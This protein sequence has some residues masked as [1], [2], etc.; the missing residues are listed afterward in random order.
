MKELLHIADGF[1][2]LLKELPVSSFA[3]FLEESGRKIR[4]IADNTVFHIDLFCCTNASAA[5]KKIMQS[6]QENETPYKLLIKNE[7]NYTV[8]IFEDPIPAVA[9][10]IWDEAMQ[11]CDALIRY[12]KKENND[13][14]AMFLV[15][16]LGNTHNIQSLI[17]QSEQSVKTFFLPPEKVNSGHLSTILTADIHPSS[18]EQLQQLSC[19]NSIR[20]AFLFLDEILASE[21]R[22]AQT[23]KLLVSQNTHITRKEEEALNNSELTINLRQLIRKTAQE[24]EKSYTAKYEDLNKPNTGRFSMVAVEQSNRL[25]ELEQKTVAEKK[26]KLDASIPKDF[27]E[28]FITTVS[29]NIRTELGKDE[30]FIKSSFEDMLTQANIQLRSKGIK[31]VNPE[32]IYPLFPDKE[33]TI[34]SFCYMNKTYTGEL[35]KKGTME[36]L[37]ALKDYTGL[38]VVIG[39]LLAPLSVIATAGDMSLFKHMAMWVKVSTGLISLSLIGYGISDLR[40]RIPK[41]RAEEFQKELNKAKELLQQEA[42][43]MFSDSSQ[44]WTSHIARWLVDTNQNIGQQMEKNIREAQLQKANRMREEKK[45]QAK[46]Q[47][48]VDLLLRNV[49]AAAQVRDKLVVQYNNMVTAIEKDLKL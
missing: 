44:D 10:I 21:T 11:E 28:Q 43:R 18:L 20:P 9:F 37:V 17:A 36:Y 46:Q 45:Q 49:Q 41:R 4:R 31:A 14:R 35:V 26:E 30:A 47:M 7:L 6:L 48:S 29:A 25:T 23:R 39:G 24:L 40:K 34:H 2:E 16:L 32:G 13:Y 3:G 15:D 22:A 5:G 19:L 27:L 1:N 42:K 8:R 12:F 33:Q 38:T